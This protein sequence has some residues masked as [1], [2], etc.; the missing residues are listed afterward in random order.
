[1]FQQERQLRKIM[2]LVYFAS[3]V[4]MSQFQVES[5]PEERLETATDLSNMNSKKHLDLKP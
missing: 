5:P 3:H 1:M 2:R 4:K